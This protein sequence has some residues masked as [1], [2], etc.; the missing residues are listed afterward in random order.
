MSSATEA[1][2]RLKQTQFDIVLADIAMPQ[3]NGYTL[4]R[5][6]R[7]MPPEQ[8]GSIPALALTAY[9]L[10]GDYQQ[11]IA[12]EFQQHITKPVDPAALVAAFANLA[13]RCSG[14]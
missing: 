1:L 14:V 8:G 10:E 5:F 6:L 7:A 12:A 11:A 13:G 4:L 3:M 9:A 2:Q